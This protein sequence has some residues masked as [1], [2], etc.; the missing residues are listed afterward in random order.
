MR[1]GGKGDKPRPISNYDEYS[2][3]WDKIFKKP[4][5]TYAGGKPHYVVEVDGSLTI[6]TGENDESTVTWN[7]RKDL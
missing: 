7:D 1:D 5:K 3:N 4:V 6:N 2:D